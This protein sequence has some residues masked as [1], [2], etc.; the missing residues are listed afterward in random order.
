[1]GGFCLGVFNEKDISESAIT[2]GRARGKG[3]QA[4]TALKASGQ[5]IACVPGI[6]GIHGTTGFG[7]G[8]LGTVREEFRK[9]GSHSCG[10]GFASHGEPEEV[11]Q[12]WGLGA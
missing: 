8:D 3:C 6:G 5:E 7:V 4:Q 9:T 1:M 2:L 10:L 12:G 11:K